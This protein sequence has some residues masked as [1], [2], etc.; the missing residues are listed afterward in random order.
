MA[1]AVSEAGMGKCKAPL[2]GSNSW[3]GLI[4]L[5]G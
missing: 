2:F 3:A 1:E 5:C 4:A